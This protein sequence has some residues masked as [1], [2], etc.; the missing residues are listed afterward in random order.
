[1]RVHVNI[2]WVEKPSN[3]RPRAAKSQ[4]EVLP[5]SAV[6]H[7]VVMVTEVWSGEFILLFNISLFLYQLFEICC[8]FYIYLHLNSHEQHVGL[9]LQIKTQFKIALLPIWGD[10]GFIIFPKPGAGIMLKGEQC[11]VSPTPSAIRPQGPRRK[12]TG[13]FNS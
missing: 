9:E 6:P 7:L 10:T 2:W 8:A 13:T 11:S 1:M 12:P 3:A 4:G 5:A